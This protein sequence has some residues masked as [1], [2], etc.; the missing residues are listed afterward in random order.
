[1]NHALRQSKLDPDCFNLKQSGSGPATN[2][3][4]R[5]MV[6]VVIIVAILALLYSLINSQIHHK[7]KK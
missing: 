5:A 4:G 7:K 1:V 2:T 6:V 3:G